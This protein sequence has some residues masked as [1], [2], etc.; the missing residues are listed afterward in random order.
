MGKVHHLSAFVFLAYKPAQWFLLSQF[1]IAVW[2]TRRYL[3]ALST[4]LK[5]SRPV[6]SLLL[7]AFRSNLSI[8]TYIHISIKCFNKLS[9]RFATSKGYWNDPYIQYFS[10]SVGERKAPE[11]NRG[12][13]YRNNHYDQ[14]TSVNNYP[15]HPHVIQLHSKYTVLNT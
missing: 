7:T 2:R 10:R 3:T 12:K 9:C 11:I 8:H 4:R 15:T 13:W 1:L 14:S 6:Q 5:P